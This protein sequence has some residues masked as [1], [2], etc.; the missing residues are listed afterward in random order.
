MFPQFQR[1]VTLTVM[2]IL[3]G[4]FAWIYV[5][6]RQ[7]RA[8]LWM[9]GWACIVVHFAAMLLF[10]FSLIPVRLANWS[11]YSTLLAAAS[12]FFLSVCPQRGR[13]R[14]RVVFW[15]ALVAPA[16]IYW[17]CMV[18]DVDNALLYRSLLAVALGAGVGLALLQPSKT[19]SSL[20]AWLV[21]AIAPGIWAA[22]RIATHPESGID[23]LLFRAL[24]SPAGAIGDTSAA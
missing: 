24:P 12:A 6:D 22:W 10:S 9:I 23:F 13:P 4:L 20:A 21:L 18:Y 7:P 16:L 11:A 5:R 1:V 8:R 3:V 14:D 19:A 15:S 2:S 17:T